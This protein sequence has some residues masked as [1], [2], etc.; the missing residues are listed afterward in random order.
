MINVDS[1]FTISLHDQEERR[2]V[3]RQEISKLHLETQWFLAE[4]DSTGNAEQGCF[5]SHVAVAKLALQNNARTLLVFED[6]VKILPFSQQQLLDLNRFLKNNYKNFDLIYLGFILGKMWYCGKRS[7]V[8]AKGVALHAYILSTTGIEKMANY[9]YNGVPIDEV[10]KKTMKC[11]SVYPMIAAQQSE[12]TAGSA[13]SGVRNRAKI[14]RIKD[15]R[16]WQNNFNK[17]KKRLWEN[18]H[19]AL[20]EFIQLPFRIFKVF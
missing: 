20:W 12:T 8:R 19:L 1:I 7:I 2:K 13:I 10:I 18:I 11:Y 17:Q 14:H 5:N 3:A 15:E 16:Y 4:R 6:D 9:E